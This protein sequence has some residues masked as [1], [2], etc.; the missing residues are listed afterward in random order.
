M[1]SNNPAAALSAK[2]AT[3][4]GTSGQNYSFLVLMANVDGASKIT[5]TGYTIEARMPLRTIDL[6]DARGAM[7]GLNLYVIDAASTGPER[8]Q[9]RSKLSNNSALA[10]VKHPDA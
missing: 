7:M 2:S 1:M 4:D 9:R 8:G 6:A 5:S 10:E 3:W